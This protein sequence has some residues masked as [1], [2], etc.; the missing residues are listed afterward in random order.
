MTVISA[1][2]GVQ[3]GKLL[4]LIGRGGRAPDESGEESDAVGWLWKRTLASLLSPSC[5]QG[6]SPSFQARFH[7]LVSPSP[8]QS[9]R[10]PP[11]PL[12]PSDFWH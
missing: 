12:G 6:F 7:L 3:V 4:G 8:G 11:V 2:E 1:D 10:A 5:T 9:W